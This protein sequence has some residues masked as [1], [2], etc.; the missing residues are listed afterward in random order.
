MI[1]VFNSG[2]STLKFGC[3]D[4]NTMGALTTGV[5]DWGGSEG[6]AIRRRASPRLRCLPAG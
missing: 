3:F 4:A 6:S 2:S 5:I 1:L